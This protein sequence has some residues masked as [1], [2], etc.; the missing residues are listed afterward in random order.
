VRRPLL[1]VVIPVY[2]EEGALP[3]LFSRLYPAL[4]RLGFSYEV[5]LVDDGSID[6]SPRILREQFARRPRQ[7]RVMLLEFNVGQHM[8]ILAGFQH[9]R[10]ERV[11]T[12]DADLQNPPEEIGK[13]LAAMDRGHDYVGGVRLDR[14]DS[15]WRRHVSRG[16]NGLRELTTRIR[17]TD[18]GC[19]LRAYDRRVVDLILRSGEVNT[20]IPALAYSYARSPAEVGV[21]HEARVAGASKYPLMRLVALNFDLMTGF[22]VAPLRIFSLAG[23]ALSMIS[24]VF[25]VYLFARRLAIG[26]EAEGVF[27]LFAISFLLIGIVLF[28]IGLL[29][30]YVGRIYE[31]VRA[32][33]RFVVRE[34]HEP[35]QPMAAR[36]EALR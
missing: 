12:M 20:F 27:T 10:G 8:A 30:E 21:A 7:T 25:V 5:I 4:D 17:L 32:R 29:G 2:N 31:Q 11:V 9:V 26:P 23:M 16:V 15:W 34:M 3:H 35:R 22:S 6:D 1:S 19:M 18:Q 13:L 24:G 36:V 33:P 14:R 28:G